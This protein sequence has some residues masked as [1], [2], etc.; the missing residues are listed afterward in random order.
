M[1]MSKQM[2]RSVNARLPIPLWDELKKIA[3]KN[4]RSVTAQIEVILEN[5]LE[6]CIADEKNEQH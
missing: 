6:Q 1:L 5:Y 2:I 4:K 3:E